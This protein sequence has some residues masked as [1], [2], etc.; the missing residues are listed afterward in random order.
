MTHICSLHNKPISSSDSGN[1]PH[2]ITRKAV[3][4]LTHNNIQAERVRESEQPTVISFYPTTDMEEIAPT[5]PTNHS[6]K[7]V[8]IPTHYNK[9]QSKR[10]SFLILIPNHQQLSVPAYD[11]IQASCISLFFRRASNAFGIRDDHPLILKH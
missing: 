1:G 2:H 4:L 6:K 5:V 3:L 9:Q 7:E 11:S 8:L 10:P